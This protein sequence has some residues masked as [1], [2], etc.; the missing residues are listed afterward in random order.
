M[1]AADPYSLDRLHDIVE[2]A[3]V[4][5]WPP[6]LGLLLLLALLLLWLTVL[7]LLAW[8]AY[9]RNR[10]RREALRLLGDIS[11]ALIDPR[12][13][14]EALGEVARLLKRTALSAYPRAQVAQLSGE[15]WLEFLDC[16]GGAGRFSQ[17]AAALLGRISWQPQAGAELS[18]QELREI[19]AAARHWIKHHQRDGRDRC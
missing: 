2:P 17:G 11:P 6:T 14:A 3:A 1:K 15:R 4:S 13:R 8:L 7:L 9:R 10:Y 18:R 19:V 5:W 16:S 12:S